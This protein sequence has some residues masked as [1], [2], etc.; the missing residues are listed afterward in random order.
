METMGEWSTGLGGMYTEEADFMNQL[1]ASYDHPCGGSSSEITATTAAYHRQNCVHWTGGSF[2]FSE[3]S[4]SYSAGNYSYYAVMPPQE[5]NNNGMKDVT[6]NTNLYLVGEETSEC[7]A[8]EYSGKSLL[9]LETVEEKHDDNMLQSE[10]LL[11]TTDDQ[12]LFNPCESSKKRSRGTSSDKNKRASKARRNQKSMEMSDDNNNNDEEEQTTKKAAAKRKTKPLKLQKTCCSDEDESNGGD[13]S[14]CK[15]GGDDSKSLNL[16]GKT[17]ASRGA[18]TD[19]QSLYARV[20][21]STML[22]EAVQ[23]VKFLQLQIKLLSSDDLWMYA[24]IAYNG[25]DIGL[26]M[27][28]NSLI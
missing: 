20:D 11:A 6:I 26:D 13:T 14:S 12:K 8:A 1:L 24:P 4:S 22:E 3:E 28:L 16:S 25:M 10:T 15:E 19:P 21:I 18:A 5:E 23:Y 2:C 17:R 7:D 27:K 9:P